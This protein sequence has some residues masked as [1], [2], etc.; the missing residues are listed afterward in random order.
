MIFL[1]RSESGQVSRKQFARRLGKP[2]GKYGA[3]GEADGACA[4]AS[5]PAHPL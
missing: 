5:G 3:G 2:Q 4:G 1:L